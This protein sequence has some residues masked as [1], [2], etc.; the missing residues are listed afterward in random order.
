MQT[1]QG[2]RCRRCSVVRFG[3]LNGGMCIQYQVQ[4]MWAARKVR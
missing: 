2:Q 4:A 1:E 3:F